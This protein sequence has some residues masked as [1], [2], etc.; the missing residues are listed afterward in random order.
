V[1]TRDRPVAIS[2]VA[3]AELAFLVSGIPDVR[4]FLTETSTSFYC[5]HVQNLLPPFHCHGKR[6]SAWTYAVHVIV[7]M[8]STK[9]VGE[10]SL[11]L[12]RNKMTYSQPSVTL[13]P[14]G[15]IAQTPVHVNAI[16]F[17]ILFYWEKKRKRW[18]DSCQVKTRVQLLLTPQKG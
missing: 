16:S 15:V 17:V 2:T 13:L 1:P 9:V 3:W 4:D 11:V 10:Q 7:N 6:G 18:S 5:W 8:F 14:F 12:H